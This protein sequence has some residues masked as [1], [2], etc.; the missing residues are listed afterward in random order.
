[1]GR[2]GKFL[3]INGPITCKEAWIAAFKIFCD[4]EPPFIPEN[5]NSSSL[6]EDVQEQLQNWIGYHIKP[7]IN[8]MCNISVMDCCDLMV[9]EAL[10]NANIVD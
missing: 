6:S 1:M 2:K 4:E 3:K 10:G 9:Q 7:E 8:W 5:G